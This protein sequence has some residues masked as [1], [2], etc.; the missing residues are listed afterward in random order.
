MRDQRLQCATHPGIV[1]G[2]H[3]A[4]PRRSRLGALT[5]FPLHALDVPDNAALLS[6]LDGCWTRIRQAA[7]SRGAAVSPTCA[8]GKGGSPPASSPPMRAA[9]STA[10]TRRL[11]LSVSETCRRC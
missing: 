5:T 3:D 11:G 4:D 7:L 8:P 10:T 6:R 9:F 1:F 2:D